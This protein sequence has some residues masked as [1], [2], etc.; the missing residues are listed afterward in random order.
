[1]ATAASVCSAAFAAGIRPE[2][3]LT[4]S[5]WADRFRIVGKPS[6]EPGPWRTERVPYAKQIMDDLSPQSPVHI[7]ALMKAAQGAGT[8]IGYNA[9]GCWMDMYPDSALLV[10]PTT[11]TLRRTS[12][13]VDRMIQATP[14]L[15][16]KVAPKRSRDRSNTIDRKEFGA[17]ELILTGA[18]SAADLR[19]NPC[20]YGMADEVDGY[21]LDLDG[22]GG[23]LDLF[24]QRLAAYARQKAYLVSTPTLEEFSQIHYWFKR[25][26]QCLFHIPC[27]ACGHVQPLLF[28]EHS[29]FAEEGLTGALKWPAGSPDLARYECGKCR[30]RFEEWVKTKILGA[31]IWVPRAPENGKG[32]IKVTSYAINA[33]YYPYGWPGNSWPALAED[34]ERNHRDPIKLKTFINLKCG[35]PWKDPTDAK[36]DA[37]TLMARRESYG[38]EL[39]AGVGVLTAGVDVQGNRLEAELCGWGK[40]EE[41]WSIDYRVF[42]GD[43]SRLTTED[44]DHPSAWEQLD[45]WLKGEWLSELGIPLSIRAG[46]IDAGFQKETVRKF[47]GERQGRRIWAILGRAGD[48][49]VWPT[50]RGRQGRSK[51]P[52]PVIVGVDAAKETVYSRLKI[53]EPGP[54]YCHFPAGRD[55][56]FFEMLT[57][58]VR[59]PDYTGPVP[60]FSWQKKT[61]GIRNESLDCRNY[62]Y[63]A[64]VGLTTL[65]AFRLNQEVDRFRRMAEARVVE[66]LGEKKAAK[67]K[68]EW[69]AGGND[70]FSG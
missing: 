32:R 43:T 44:R 5:Q 49:P 12:S 41:S 54:G 40:D 31:G 48:K 33:L 26:N 46:C 27:P 18:N 38:P 65:T 51:Y 55:R 35:E 22:E 25:G 67:P 7:V 15:R 66:G 3:D 24:L 53:S 30:E 36:A 28:S 1:M 14:R 16:E 59:V 60:K 69:I 45:N 61:K 56:D 10:T 20:R 57:S 58:E 9:L 17:D 50:K 11:K 63:A 42:V 23:A 37:D 21:P 52:A 13:R 6:P 70:W 39:P 8:E 29:I 47:C 64:L 34:W 2:P 62:N 68:A 4:V 19:S